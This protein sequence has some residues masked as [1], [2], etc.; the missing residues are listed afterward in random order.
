MRKV[1]SRVLGFNSLWSDAV[2]EKMFNGS[3]WDE[4]VAEYSKENDSFRSWYKIMTT[5]AGCDGTLAR[6]ELD[7]FS[8]CVEQTMEEMENC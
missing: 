1:S 8:G 3:N 2:A 6:D 4:S 5:V 7:C